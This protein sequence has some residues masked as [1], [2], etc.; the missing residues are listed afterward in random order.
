PAFIITTG[1]KVTTF[2][3]GNASGTSFILSTVQPSNITGISQSCSHTTSVFNYCNSLKVELSLNRSLQLCGNETDCCP[4]PLCVLETLRVLAC[5]GTSPHATLLVQAHIY[6]VLVPTGPMSEN[7]TVIPN[8]AYQPLGPCPCDLTW[9]TCDVRC[10]CDQDCSPDVLQLFKSKCFPGVFGGNV[11]PPPDYQCSVQSSTNNPDWFPFLCVTSPCD[12]SPYLGLFFQG[13]TVTPR[14]SPSFQA[15]SVTAPLVVAV[16]CQ[17]DP[18][19]R[20]DGQ[21]FTIPQR[22]MVGQCVD[23]APVAFLQNFRFWC[24]SRLVSCPTGPPLQTTA[25]EL[26][27]RVR[28][29]FGGTV[30]VSVEEDE[31]RDL[32]LFVSS[33]SPSLVPGQTQASAIDP[34]RNQLDIPMC[35][36]M[37]L[38]MDYT[39]TWRANGLVHVTLIRTVGS[40]PLDPGASVTA[41]YSAVFVNWNGSAEPN[42]GNPGYIIGKPVIGGS[43]DKDTG[44]IQRSPISLW[45][46]VG[47]GL[48]ASAGKKPVMFDE[49]ATAGCLL[50]LGAQDLEQCSQLRDTV[51]VGLAALVTA[52]FVARKGNPSAADLADWVNITFIPLNGS[53]SSVSPPGVC[54]HIPSH[55]NIHIYSTE[56]WSRGSLQRLILAMEVSYTLSTWRVK[57]GGGDPRPCSE[58]SVTHSFPVTSAVTFINIPAQIPPPKTRFQIN[59]TE[60]DCDRNDVCWPQLAY[61]LT[62]YYTGEAYCLS[63]AKGLTLII[64]FISASL[65]GNPW[66]QICQ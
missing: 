18:I 23:N 5:Q 52:T 60:F 13:Y 54:E 42:S 66:K 56:A 29:G 57:C 37:T 50:R 64:I 39:F 21:Y 26:R 16:Y 24:P 28:D 15:P 47:E 65:L 38:A 33:P 53:T 45:Q 10:C 19:F 61:P 43:L 3:V 62:R 49:N 55:L 8:Q 31:A 32:S 7:K 48:C 1:P 63:L 41:R 4:Q 27:V 25:S 46:P 34:T 35:H 36:N 20:D 14:R 40:V 2:L 22:S 9:N 30:T 12:N 44:S 6:A 51:R 58:A 59:F 17:G 11:M